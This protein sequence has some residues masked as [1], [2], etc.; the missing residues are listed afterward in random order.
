MKLFK[1]FKDQLVSEVVI[2]SII[3]GFS[4]GV[5]GQIVADV[6]INPWEIDGLSLSNTN[7]NSTLAVPE[8]QRVKKFVGIE[9]DFE[10][11]KTVTKIYPALC[12]V[13]LKKA[14]SGG[15]LSRVYLPGEL[16]A[17]GL[18][19]T[20]DGWIMTYDPALATYKKEQLQISVSQKLYDADALVYDKLT[21]V[22]F[23]KISANNLPVVALGDSAEAAAGQLAVTLNAGSDAAVL[24]IQ[25]PEFIFLENANSLAAPAEQFRKII[26][27][28]S[29]LKGNYAG[30]PVANLD[31]EIIGI[32]KDIGD[33]KKVASAIP[34]NQVRPAALNVLR[35]KQVK[36]PFLGV[37]YLDLAK[38]PGLPAVLSQGLSAGALI[39]QNPKAKSPAALAGLKINDIIVSVDNQ[40]LDQNTDLTDVIMQYS[41]QAKVRLEI[42]RAGKTESIDAT[43][44]LLPE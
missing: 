4:A 12:G 20:S 17:T 19:F 29:A 39:Y 23:I 32:I 16:Q 41:P 25:N 11:N 35:S 36:R 43:L 14:E 33:Q 3:F 38:A 8:L 37:T 28:T 31:G 40:R 21:G 42:R 18:I 13:Y 10:V 7:E 5:A 30:G 6:Y 24:N 2:V 22:W 27:F 44:E 34:I 9:Q 15:A 1:K 26:N